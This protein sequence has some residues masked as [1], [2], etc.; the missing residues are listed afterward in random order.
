MNAM[1]LIND[2]FEKSPNQTVLSRYLS[3]N[4]VLYLGAGA[5]LL[6]WPGSV[7]TLLGDPAFVGREE[8]LIRVIGLTVVIIGLLYLLGGRANAKQII[9]V[10]IVSR[11]ILVP[12]ALVP[13]AIAGV[14]PHLLLTYVVLDMLLSIGGGLLARKA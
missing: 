8:G 1:Q 10:S 5:L 6:L 7:Q 13:L 14:F 9:A 12:L 11:P 3:L 2:L 4:G